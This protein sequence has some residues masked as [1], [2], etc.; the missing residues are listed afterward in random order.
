MF[1]GCRSCRSWTVRRG[2]HGVVYCKVDRQAHR[3]RRGSCR[4]Q[5]RPWRAHG[6]AS[7][8]RHFGHMEMRVFTG[9]PHIIPATREAFLTVAQL[10]TSDKSRSSRSCICLYVMLCRIC[11]LQIKPRTRA[12]DQADHTAPTR[13]HG[14]DHVDQEPLCP[15]RSRSW[16]RWW[17]DLIG[18]VCEAGDEPSICPA[19]SASCLP[20]SNVLTGHGPFPMEEMCLPCA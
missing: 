8:R 2:W 16:S 15:D 10:F 4:V 11:M 18:L 20:R 3:R 1:L 12:I 19:R 13:Q 17:N 9:H 5:S 14:L 6:Q 7:L